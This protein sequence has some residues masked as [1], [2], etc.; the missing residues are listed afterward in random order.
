MSKQLLIQYFE[1]LKKKEFLNDSSKA[2]V[3]IK[4]YPD[5][6]VYT[7]QDLYDYYIDLLTLGYFKNQE[8]AKEAEELIRQYPDEVE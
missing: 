3:L 2:E 7:K 8:I 1:E 5:E 4:T 6:K